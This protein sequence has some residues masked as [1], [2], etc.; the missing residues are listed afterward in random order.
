MIKSQKLITESSLRRLI[1]KEI[2]QQRLNEHASRILEESNSKKAI[3]G[4]ILAMLAGADLLTKDKSFDEIKRQA[5]SMISSSDHHTQG[6][7]KRKR[8]PND[9]SSLNSLAAQ[10]LNPAIEK[11]HYYID[12]SKKDI[13]KSLSFRGWEDYVEDNDSK[14]KIADLM[15]DLA[16][17]TSKDLNR[18]LK[19]MPSLK[20]DLE[21]LKEIYESLT[22][23]SNKALVFWAEKEEL[24]EF[25]QQEHKDL[26]DM[27]EKV[28]GKKPSNGNEALTQLTQFGRNIRELI[29]LI[30]IT[31]QYAQGG[32]PK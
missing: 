32:G 30:Q 16:K 5:Q 22:R 21:G 7:K 28:T 14:Q 29:E 26:V 2:K 13:K 17:K 15:V 11:L 4:S 24:L 27:L 6:V 9:F 12:A 10:D 31:I 23:V 19:P 25:N 8:F 3:I 1:A 18:N 20:E